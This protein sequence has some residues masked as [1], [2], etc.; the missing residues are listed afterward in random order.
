MRLESRE[1]WELAKRLLIIPAGLGPVLALS[2]PGGVGSLSYDGHVWALGG[3]AGAAGG[4][5]NGNGNGNGP[6]GNAAAT[7]SAPG[8]GPGQGHGHASA[9]G[10]ANGHGQPEPASVG[11]ATA[12]HG[13]ANAHGRVLVASALGSLNAAHGLPTA[14]ANAS[15]NSVV[16][17]LGAYADAVRGWATEAEAQAMLLDIAGR[18]IDTG[19]VDAVN[20]QLG[21][22]F[23]AGAPAG[24]TGADGAQAAADTGN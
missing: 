9:Q 16:G 8:G 23:V 4:G 3:G 5:G 14:L 2:V 22:D 7:A 19:I 13:A 17:M 20:A 18:D 1:I 6:G 11:H 12:G 21:V 15:P 10:Q 24:G